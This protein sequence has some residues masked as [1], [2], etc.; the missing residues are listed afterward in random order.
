MDVGITE[1]KKAEHALRQAEARF[2]SLF[3]AA[4]YAVVIFEPKTFA[5]LAFNDRACGVLGYAREE[6][7]RLTVMDIDALGDMEAIRRKNSSGS[8]S[9]AA[10]ETPCSRSTP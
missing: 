5:V 9:T 3:D 8:A 2:R 1:A 10:A 4:R 7:A 6:F